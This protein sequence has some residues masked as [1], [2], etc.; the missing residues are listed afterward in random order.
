M[1]HMAA[2]MIRAYGPYQQWKP[3]TTTTLWKLAMLL[4]ICLEN[5]ANGSKSTKNPVHAVDTILMT[6]DRDWS[7][8]T[9]SIKVLIMPWSYNSPK[10]GS[11]TA[12][13]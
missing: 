5:S 11:Q 7:G 6:N 13:E 12:A 2:Q 3:L 4:H 1:A 10:V 8:V 9:I